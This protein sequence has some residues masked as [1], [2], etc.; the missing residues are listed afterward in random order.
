MRWMP[1]HAHN[2]EFFFPDVVPFEVDIGY[3]P[4]LLLDLLASDP[5]RLDFEEGLSY[6]EKL[7]K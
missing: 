4:W 7:F 6:V 2:A 5:Q 3:I 1:V